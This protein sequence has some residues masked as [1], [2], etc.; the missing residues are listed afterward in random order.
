[1]GASAGHFP[2]QFSR[3]STRYS[4]S[5]ED[6][7]N[8]SPCRRAH[9]TRMSLTQSP[10]AAIVSGDPVAPNPVL[11][12]A[13]ALS[14]ETSYFDIKR[15][16][17]ETEQ[18]GTSFPVALPAT[19]RVDLCDQGLSH[20]KPRGH[21]GP[22]RPQTDRKRL[23]PAHHPPQWVW[24]VYRCLPCKGSVFSENRRKDGHRHQAALI[25]V[26]KAV[27]QMIIHH[28]G[29]LQEGIADGRTYEG[30]PRLFERSAHAVR[31]VR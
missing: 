22:C 8:T 4:T 11:A 16:D 2:P 10:G 19:R 6:T 18:R 23:W 26:A 12:G 27:H 13:K 14:I 7:I 9:E 28:T 1:M 5:F 30:E 31:Q 15:C 25:P 29:R 21:V 17:Y 3:L 20:G 24:R